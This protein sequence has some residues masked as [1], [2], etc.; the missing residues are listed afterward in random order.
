MP[1][2]AW[3][4]GQ[5]GL[6]PAAGL[7]PG[8]VM[9]IGLDGTLARSTQ[10]YQSSVAGGVGCIGRRRAPVGQAAWQDGLASTGGRYRLRALAQP[11]LQGN[12]CC[13][14]YLPCARR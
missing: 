12:G 11:V 4:Y 10:A 3:R 9:A 7:E 6:P 13:C 8:E 14:T 1:S 5:R 2:T